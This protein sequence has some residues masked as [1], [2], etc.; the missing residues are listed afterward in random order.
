MLHL[1]WDRIDMLGIQRARR[2]IM[3]FETLA[4]TGR[5]RVVTLDPE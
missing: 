1:T 3:E 2:Q 5:H 4:I